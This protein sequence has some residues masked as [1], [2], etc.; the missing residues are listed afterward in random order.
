MPSEDVALTNEYDADGYY[1]RRKRTA[2]TIQE[3]VEICLKTAKAYHN[4]ANVRFRMGHFEEAGGYFEQKQRLLNETIE[5]YQKKMRRSA[6]KSTKNDN[7]AE[8]ESSVDAQSD[9]YGYKNILTTLLEEMLDKRIQCERSL[10]DCYFAR[11]CYEEA[12]QHYNT[13]LATSEQGAASASFD[14]EQVYCLLGKCY[15]LVNNLTQALVVYEKRFVIAH[16]LGCKRTKAIAYGELGH[17]HR[18]LGNY[19]KSI[20]FFQKEQELAKEPALRSQTEILPGAGLNISGGMMFGV[21][22]TFRPSGSGGNSPPTRINVGLFIEAEALHGLGCVAQEMHDYE[23]A[24]KYHSAA[25]AISQEV[26]SMELEFQAYGAMG[27]SYNA[28][29][30]YEAAV[31][32]HQKYLSVAH[33]VGDLNAQLSALSALGKIHSSTGKYGEAVKYLQQGLMIIE[34]HQVSICHRDEEEA[35]LC[36]ELGM[37]LWALNDLEV[38]ESHLRRSVD[39][40]EELHQSFCMSSARTLVPP[41]SNIYGTALMTS[42]PYEP[43][44]SDASGSSDP[45]SSSSSSHYAQFQLQSLMHQS[46]TS[47]AGGSQKQ[48]SQHLHYQGAS[49]EALIKILIAL[50]RPTE[51]LLIAERSRMR[52]FSKPKAG[53]K[54]S[55]ISSIEQIIEMARSQNAAILYYSMTIDGSYNSWLITPKGVLFAPLVKSSREKILQHLSS[56]QT[57]LLE[58][59]DHGKTFDLGSHNAA[60]DLESVISDSCLMSSRSMHHLNRNHFLNSSNYSLSSLFSLASSVASTSTSASGAAT[61]RHRSRSHGRGET[62][63]ARSSSGRFGGSTS[64]ISTISAPETST[65]T[66]RKRSSSLGKRGSSWHGSASLVTLYQI[67]VQH[68]QDQ[69]D[70]ES[71]LTQLLLVLDGDLF[72]IPW[73]MLRNEDE[74]FLSERYSLLIIPSLHVL[75]GDQGTKTL[76]K[77]PS[78]STITSLVVANP[79]M[80]SKMAQ[81]GPDGRQEQVYYENPASSREAAFVSEILSTRPLI[82]TEANKEAVLSQLS[83]AQCIH[84]SSYIIDNTGGDPL[85][86]ATG[87][88]IAISPSDVVIGDSAHQLHDHEYLLTPHD[89]ISIGL[90]AKLVV[91]SCCAL[92]LRASASAAGVNATTTFSSSQALKTITSALLQAGASCVL[93]TLWPVPLSA[94]QVLFR[95]FYCSLLQGTRV[96]AALN[97]AVSTIQNTGHFSHPRNWAGFLLIGSDVRLSS[98]VALMSSSLATLLK[99]PDRSRDAMRVVLHLVEKSLQRIQRGHKNAMYTTVQSIENKIGPNTQ[100]WRELLIAVGF[101]FEPAS[102]AGLP[103]C[104]FFPQSDPSDRLLRCSTALQAILALSGATIAA[105]SKLLTNSDSVAEIIDQLFKVV[106]Q[107]TNGDTQQILNCHLETLNLR[108][109]STPGCHELYASLGFD[110][111]EVGSNLVTLRA[112]K[113]ANL[114][115]IVFTLQTLQALYDKENLNSSSLSSSSCSPTERIVDHLVYDEKET[116]SPIKAIPEAARP[117]DENIQFNRKFFSNFLKEIF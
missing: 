94:L 74:E 1:G 106:Q 41:A 63:I 12:I 88:G 7:Q 45:S 51:A 8:K 37:A 5:F 103:A 53:F 50:K 82:G 13:F 78:H 77:T 47:G 64:N 73:S 28:I 6:S 31:N 81:T 26:G 24:L 42:N 70:E 68:F 87:L 101:R 62:S 18:Q 21:S 55:S 10:G 98:Q 61:T 9:I 115:T 90:S 116:Q 49:Y 2:D 34:Q 25:L 113:T 54:V 69:L 96:S 99:T 17:I 85:R 112:G 3:F 84:F 72:L 80:P 117:N 89:L 108:L 38:A 95:I 52:L 4:V 32:Y 33:L 58:D 65:T 22:G 83:N 100:G 105:I 46:M 44:G 48:R 79:T 91:I 59:V 35:R 71:S 14:Q 19:E 110:L 107:E 29:G 75:R 104:V 109:W 23:R 76:R 92:S 57:N 27:S 102:A 60:D 16:T 97:E 67:L 43:S 15:Q 39:L 114:R 20:E 40:I 93:L 36:Y 11:G 111:M 86:M 56:V 30:N 66:K